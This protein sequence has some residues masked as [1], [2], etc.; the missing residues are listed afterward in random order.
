MGKAIRESSIKNTVGDKFQIGYVHSLLEKKT[1]LVCACG[2]FK[3]GWKETEHQSDMED[4]DERR[5]FGEN[6]HHPMTWKVM[7]RSAWKEIAN[8]QTKQLNSYTK[9]ATPCI[10]DI[11]SMKKK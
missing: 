6:Q 9:V 3:I 2:R 5:G 11:N 4:T 10:D 8:W 7:Q 1:I